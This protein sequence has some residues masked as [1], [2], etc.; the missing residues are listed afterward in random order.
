MLI[1]AFIAVDESRACLLY[2]RH[3][4]YAYILLSC[5]LF[6]VKER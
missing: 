2:L 5:R 1:Y 3:Y 6:S 4:D